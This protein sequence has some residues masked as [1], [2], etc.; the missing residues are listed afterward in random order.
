M[1]LTATLHRLRIELSDVERGVYESLDLRVAQEL[2]RGRMALFLGVDNL[3]DAG[4][5]LYLP[6]VPRGFYGGFTVRT[7]SAP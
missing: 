3:L 2:F 4:D 6:L 1:A 7:R 5:A